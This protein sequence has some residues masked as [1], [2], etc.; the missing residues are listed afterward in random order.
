VH[1]QLIPLKK[2]LRIFFEI[3]DI[4]ERTC[5]YIATLNKDS[6]GEIFNIIQTDFWK[7]KI[8]DSTSITFL[9]FLYE[10]AFET[11]N[12]LGSHAGIYKLNGIYISIP[13]LP[14]QLY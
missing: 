5:E 13:C 6:N 8:T 1:G 7:L 9:L 14:P 10:D 3:G 2:V 12:P 11:G 4:F